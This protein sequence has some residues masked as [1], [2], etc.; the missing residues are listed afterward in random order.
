VLTQHGKSQ[1]CYSLSIGG[2][3]G[4]SDEKWNPHWA[5]TVA[6]SVVVILLCNKAI[7]DIFDSGKDLAGIRNFQKEIEPLPEPSRRKICR[8]WKIP[9]FL[10][11]QSGMFQT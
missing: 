1:P 7:A 3:R 2:L 8:I 4:G 10:R 5:G 11:G 6:E 9:E